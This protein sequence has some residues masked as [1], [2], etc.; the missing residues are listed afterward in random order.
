MQMF[1][2]STGPGVKRCSRFQSC[3]FMYVLLL[4]SH[5]SRVWLCDPIDGSPPG[6]PIPEILQIRT[7]E[8]VAIS[9]SNAWKWKGNRSVVSDSSRDPGSIPGWGRSP[10]EGNGSPFQ[11]SCLENPMERGSWWLQSMRLQRVRHDLVTKPP[12]YIRTFE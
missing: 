6:F 8:W 7:V 12:H 10:G 11:Y 4:L 1:R 2:K 3:S 5:F 9:F